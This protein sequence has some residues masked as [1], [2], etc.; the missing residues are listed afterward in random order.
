MIQAGMLTHVYNLNTH[1]AETKGSRVQGQP[2]VHSK[3]QASLSYIVKP[4]VKKK[5]KFQSHFD[6]GLFPTSSY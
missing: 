5:K 6:L 1:E 3:F 2:G 4:Y